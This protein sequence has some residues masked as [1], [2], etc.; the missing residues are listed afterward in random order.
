LLCF[1]RMDLVKQQQSVRSLWI[2]QSEELST[3]DTLPSAA[4]QRYEV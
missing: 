4:G 1:G 2:S 3:A